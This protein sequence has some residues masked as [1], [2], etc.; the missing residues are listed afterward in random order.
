[1]ARMLKW[2]G[3]AT[4]SFSLSS[5]IVGCVPQEK[6]NAKVLENSALE[7]Q[8]SNA[9]QEASTAQAQA[10]AYRQ[11]MDELDQRLTTDEAL[12]ANLQSQDQDLASRNAALQA[13]LDD[14]IKNPPKVEQI[15]QPGG[16]GNALPAPLSNALSEFAAANPGVVEFDAARGVVKF[17]SDVTFATGSAELT[18]Q[19][20]V[21]IDKFA[22]ILNS[23]AA[24]SYE[25]QV[26]GHTDNVPVTNPETK[27]R[28]HLDNWY[29]SAHR[30]I[31]VGEELIS[32]NVGRSRL[33]MVGYG[34]QRPIAD[35][36]TSAG[37]R[38]NRRVEVLILPT[39][40]IGPA[41]QAADTSAPRQV[42]H[43]EELNKDAA[44]VEETPDM[45]K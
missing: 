7:E 35:N 9:Q 8:L 18:P 26:A 5:V 17:K 2:L 20:R 15:I 31:S 37:R 10:A 36:G 14:A 3:L 38:M 1:M 13:Q 25:L 4:L 39:H 12:K 41:I 16:G 24:A 33:A 44:A 30:A 34:D 27:R 22:T 21:V 6:Y 45:N 29:L 19:A 11:N 28:G 32:Q 23:P 40:G 43:H 42:T